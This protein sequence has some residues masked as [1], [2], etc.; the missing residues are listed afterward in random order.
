MNEI[1]LGKIVNTHGIKGEIRLLSNFE[2]KD[3]VFKK[4]FPIYIG[5]ERNKELIATYRKHK[6]FDMIKVEGINDINDILKYKGKAVYIDRNDL[7][8]DNYLDEDLIGFSVIT[9]KTIGKV[10]DIIKRPYQKIIKI[11][12]DNKQYM[13]PFVDEFVKEID[14]KNK[15]I[16]IHTIEGLIYEN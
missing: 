5:K 14:L 3:Q 15:Q 7:K 1:Y 16:K 11:S 9:D 8:I 6:I 4:G 10:V 13:I 12:V 2:Y